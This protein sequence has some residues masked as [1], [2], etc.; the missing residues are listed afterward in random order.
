MKKLA[1]LFPLAA[2]LVCSC[3]KEVKDPGMKTSVQSETPQES[4]YYKGTAIVQFDDSVLSIVESAAAAGTVK[5][6]SAE[7]NDIL[8]NIGASRIERSFPDAGPREKLHREFGLHRFYT[9]TFDENVPRTRASENLSLMKGVI[10]VEIP[11]KMKM[12]SLPWNDPYASRAWGL[13]NTGS[14]QGFVEGAD[15]NVLPVYDNVTAGIREVIVGVVDEGVDPDHSDLAGVVV[16]P[17][18][19]GSKNFCDPYNQ[20][21]ITPGKHGCNVGGII[22][23]INNNG[24]FCCGVAGGYDGNGGVSILTC[25]VFSDNGSYKNF[26]EAIV[27]ACDHGALVCNNSWGY[28][29]DANGNGVIDPDEYETICNA[30]VDESLIRSIEYFNTYAGCDENGNQTGLMKG[31][32][33]FFSSGN[34]NIDR[35]PTGE[36]EQ[37]VAVGAIGPDGRRASYSNYGPWVDICAPGGDSYFGNDGYI[38]SLSTNNSVVGMCGTSQAT[39]YVSGAA[40]LLISAHGKKG[41]T[42]DMLRAQLIDNASHRFDSVHDHP[43]GPLVDTYASML[44]IAEDPDPITSWSV[45]TESNRAVFDITVPGK[46]TGCVVAVSEDR[47][48]L[49]KLTSLSMTPGVIGDH[50]SGVKEGEK[51]NIVAKH[52]KYSTHYYA[53]VYSVNAGKLRVSSEIKEITTP[54]NQLPQAVDYDGFYALSK[55]DTLR[56]D[57]STIFVD[58]DGDEL[59]FFVKKDGKAAHSINGNTITITQKEY[60]HTTFIVTAT[61]EGGSK[62]DNIF[63]FVLHDREYDADVYPNPVSL[64][65]N[66]DCILYLA[67]GVKQPVETEVVITNAAGK[68]LWKCTG[69]ASGL[70]P[71]AVDMASWG[72]GVYGV[73]M[74][75]DGKVYEER[76]MKI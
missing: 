19:D 53:A 8:V 52:L 58:P 40:A 16:P 69:A 29:F 73:R 54:K 62:V 59:T 55:L 9:V 67:P 24:N 37:V 32:I 71:F 23:A 68:V 65:S 56:L 74:S 27:W 60:G 36:L 38:W 11:H 13:L 30:K 57:M 45:K 63:R 75:F 7:M 48:S 5:T 72:V 18:P 15:I 17:G 34:D 41:Y 50:I 35:A 42:A 26:G 28:D 43:I 1:C 4:G 10:S 6:K 31:G 20:Y 64:D 25:E 14:Y 46:T 21:V 39:P 70:R 2:L 51:H 49:L 22:G 47:E 44:A 61:D 3:A 66:G 76:V 33:C 12:H